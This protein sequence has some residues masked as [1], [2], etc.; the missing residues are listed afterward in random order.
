VIRALL[1]LVALVALAGCGGGGDGAQA[2]GREI[3]L[4]KAL[5]QG[6][7]VLVMR[8]A[9][10]ETATDAVEV[11]GDCSRQRN[12]SEAGR[13]QARRLGRDIKALGV[14]VQTVLASPLCRAK[15][16]AE[17]AFGRGTPTRVLVSPGVTGTI[18]G[19]DRRIARL[20]GMT[21][22]PDGSATVLVTHTGNIGGAFE[23]SV[24]EGDT[25]VF[26][27]GNLLGTVRPGDWA[28]LKAA[29]G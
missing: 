26:G 28:R 27:D 21:S 6:G 7:V 20:R 16:T 12:L 13:A 11:L 24:E 29:L 15:E 2:T 17:L 8:H 19:D 18:A 22:A 10:T 4:A 5:R 23:Q 3:A 14:P 9:E 1:A 25:L